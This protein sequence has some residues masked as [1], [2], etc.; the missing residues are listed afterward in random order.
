[1]EAP[2]MGLARGRILILGVGKMQQK[3]RNEMEMEMEGA[4]VAA[5]V[6]VVV[7]WGASW[8]KVRRP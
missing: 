4:V 5:A 1:M 2:L 6:V 7:V 8:C 3:M